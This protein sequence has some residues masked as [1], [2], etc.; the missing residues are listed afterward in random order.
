M[1]TRIKAWR[2]IRRIAM[3]G[4]MAAAAAGGC[5]GS[6]GTNTGSGGDRA[7]NGTIRIDEAALVGTADGSQVTLDIP[8]EALRH[9][10]G[11]LNVS[12][13]SVDGA[14]VLATTRTSYDIPAGQTKHLSAAFSM[15][16]DVSTQA[17]WV[18]DNLRIDDGSAKGLRVT[19]SMLRVMSPY[20]LQLEGPENLS[21]GKTVSYR[22]HAQNP[23][24]KQPRAGQAVELDIEQNK[25]VVDKH[26]AT[27]DARGDAVIAVQIQQTGSFT[28]LARAQ[29]EGTLESLSGGVQVAEPGRKVLLTTDKPVYQ[30]GQTIHL[31][32]LALAPPENKPLANKAVTFEVEDGKGNKILKRDLS[33][34][35]YGIAATDFT[36]GRILNLGTFKVSVI[37]DGTTTEKT[38]SVSHYA[39][40]KFNVG[41]SVDRTWYGPGDTLKGT[42]DAGYFFG[43]PVAGASVTIEGVK[44]D[45]G[46][47]V[48]QKVVGQT[49]SAGQM[50]FSL[51]L[52]KSLVGL[53]LEQGNA[54][55]NVRATVTD[56]AG[57][58]VQKE[59]A[60]TVAQNAVHIVL[61]PEATSLVPGVANRLQLFVSDPLGAPIGSATAQITAG[62]QTLDTTT[63]AF[64]Y[65]E[66]S[67]KP[68]AGASAS[69]GVTVTPK[70]G[71]PVSQKFDFTE[72][73]GAEH[74]LV[75]TD[76]A[77]YAIGDTV[78][79]QVVVDKPEAH[80]YVDWLNDGQAVDMRTLDPVNGVASFTMPLDTSLLG[81]NRVEAYVVD[82]DG[83]EIRAG[84]TLFA[85]TNAAL[86]VSMTTDKSQY[87]PGQPA[88]LTFSVKDENGNPAVAALG[89]QVVDE[90]VF[91]LIDARPGLLSTYFEL[92][93]AYSQPQYEIQA[94]P[95]SLTDLLFDKTRS[96]DPAQAQAAQ[97][98]AQASFAALGG[99]SFTG[100]SLGSWSQVQS[101]A[102][103][104]L[105]P[106]YE[107]EK[108]RLINT[109]R[110][111]VQAAV[112]QLVLQGCS[113]QDYYCQALGTDFMSALVAQLKGGFPVYDFWGNRY[114]DESTQYG[115]SIVLTTSGPDEKAG[116][117]DDSTINIQYSELGLDIPAAYPPMAGG[118]TG[119]SGGFDNAGGGA[120]GASMGGSSGSGGSAGGTAAPRVRRDFPETLYVNPEVITGPDGK[121]TVDVNMA[122]SITQWR[123]STLAHSADGKLGGGQGGIKVFQDFFA[124][125]SFPATL[126]RGDEVSFPIAVYNYLSTPQTVKLVLSSGS[127]YTPLGATTQSVD[128]GPGEVVGAKF[129]VRVDQVGVQTLTVTATGSA[130]SD[131][132]ARQ[133]L[134]V[135]D[136]KEFPTALSGSLAAG[137]TQQSVSFPANAVPGSD[138][139]YLE[140]YPAF[141]SQVV[142][143]MDSMLQV[144]NGCFEQTT[145]TTWP[146]VLVTRYMTQTGQITPAIQIKAE[147][148]ISAGYQRLLTFE[149]KG[150]GFSWFGE[151]DPAPFLSVTA[152]GLMEFADMAKVQ[153]VDPAMVQRTVS[154]LVGQQQTDG[155]WKG[156]QSEFFTFQTSTL[157]NT[158]FVVWALADNGY[159][160]PEMQ[161]G[162]SYVKSQLG[163]DEDPYTLGLVANA[164]AK[165]APADPALTTV[166]ADLDKK[167]HVDGDKLYWDSEGTQTNFYGGG[168]DANVAAT[169]LVAHALILAGGYAG[170]VDGALT[171]LT[172]SKDEYGNF[173]ST[174][175][176]IWTLRTLLLAAEKGTQGAVGSF[177]VDV[178]G[179]P[180]TTLSLTKDKAD[181]MTTVDMKPFATTGS[182]QIKLSFVGTGKVSYN[183]VAKHNLA[184][185]DVPPDPTGPLS[186][187][188]SYDK[189]ALNVDDTVQAT[190]NVVNNTASI[191]NMVIATL[192]IPP[193][194]QVLTEDL[195][196]YKQNGQLSSYEMTGKQLILYLSALSPSSTTTFKY[197]LRATMPVKASDGGG[198]AYLYYQP[199]QKASAPET[200]LQAN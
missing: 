117:A 8:V 19:A 57:Q 110:P 90:A 89:V 13:R 24:T 137:S 165:A 113:T 73:A 192:G 167:K 82:N 164:F 81:T 146:N 80:V 162:L 14:K 155:S 91:S 37:V 74:V 115:Y 23:F 156:D 69:V 79:V 30:P 27:T 127:W 136:G 126:T 26:M 190:V 124:D 67:W 100:L 48:F 46:E 166:L 133:V 109:I 85:R 28:V 183:L 12:L 145:S 36:L 29:A 172:S 198:E 131:A 84:R 157:R 41:V 66:V 78:K 175:A 20:E 62:G 101:N 5:S 188:I 70:N 185:A 65:A 112:A 122:D 199:D 63:D 7:S 71:A 44:L 102:Q 103:Q 196:A 169:A 197:R 72:Q 96:S 53:P 47:T 45:V 22:I 3:L 88:K 116:T 64:G 179:T 32:A 6:P 111:V 98:R 138:E 194:F 170:D 83:N 86:D 184:W 94:P 141:L 130:A 180:F 50:A 168:E 10:S 132:L 154:W 143:G 119:G 31:R 87:R 52:P 114:A 59:T 51:Q 147:S 152:F 76:K 9:A 39:L 42:L 200:V 55:L 118:G 95:G 153:P 25:K 129:P 193:G 43:K 49:N 171:Y 58:Q 125:I 75:R 189:S 121:A 181:L 140:V 17:D 104:I 186:I 187:T 139:L 106:Y 1:S 33:T 18:R 178:D 15:P 108:K 191:Q 135:P 97:E 2:R 60:V 134:V 159:T 11:K 107:A 38:V 150:G 160:G 161:S 195:D 92:E 34:D 173:G 148:L 158:A 99:N 16:A 93:D 176:T 182:H 105:Q 174:Q 68:A 35:S 4:V 21:K 144:P 120:A 61:V 142:T 40:P 77:V 151:Q 56:T 54:L 163:T 123:V 177:A 128:V 149:H